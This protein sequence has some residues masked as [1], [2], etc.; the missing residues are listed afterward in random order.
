[1]STTKERDIFSRASK[2][3][4]TSTLLFPRD[5]REDVF[6][7][8]SFVRVADDY[9]D[10]VPQQVVE[11]ED[12]IAEYDRVAKL[13][14]SELGVLETD[15]IDTRVARNMR[16]VE[17][18]HDF[19]PVWTRTFLAAMRADTLPTKYNTLDDTLRYV[20][21]SAEVIGFMMAKLMNVPQGA[22]QAAA[23][24]GRAMQYIN[25]VRDI[26]EDIRLGRN[27]F[28][29]VD[30]KKYDLPNLREATAKKRPDE[31]REFI[32]FE[33]GR[34]RE[35]QKQADAGMH[36]IPRRYRLPIQTAAAAYGWTAREIERDPFVVYRRKVKP[37]RARLIGMAI[38]SAAGLK[39]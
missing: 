21:G 38:K 16:S 22:M 17:L 8:Y 13:G 36:Y 11:F 29:A 1:M 18:R 5:V 14:V 15:N 39:P 31:F 32:R 26:A 23:M 34:Y 28:P 9:V 37:S 25:F 12:L 6:R 30:L 20:H 35:W 7:L 27:Y 2:T 24:Q 4:Y 10:A 19:D 3:Y 33:L